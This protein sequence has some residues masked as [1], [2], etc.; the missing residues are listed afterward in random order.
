MSRRIHPEAGTH[1]I[2]SVPKPKK[3]MFWLARLFGKNVSTET[4]ECFVTAY[5]YRGV[6]YVT[7]IR[8]KRYKIDHDVGYTIFDEASDLPDGFWDNS[9]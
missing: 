6:L 8:H 3:Y 5:R 7:K 4:S 2:S 9:K 1:F